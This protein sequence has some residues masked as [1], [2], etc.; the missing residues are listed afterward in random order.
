MVQAKAAEDLAIGKAPQRQHD[1]PGNQFPGTGST[2]RFGVMLPT[3]YGWQ[4]RAAQLLNVP[5]LGRLAYIALKVSG[6]EIPRGVQIGK[7]FC[8][9]HGSVGLV[10][11]PGTI[12][13]RNVR[14]YGGVTIGRS[15]TYLPGAT[16]GVRDQIVIEDDVIVGAGAK[17]LYK[18]GSGGI[19]LGRGCVIGANAV[20]LSSVSAGEIWAGSPA[21]RVSDRPG[22]D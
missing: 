13:G 2:S 11:Y 12:I 21:R 22:Y 14:I 17:V 8:L 5:K 10:V 6:I 1:R 16:G 19:R 3:I 15:D 4:E 7:G 18:G 9:P 20:V